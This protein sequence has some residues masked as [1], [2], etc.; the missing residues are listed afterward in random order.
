M[1]G[2]MVVRVPYCK[3]VESQLWESNYVKLQISIEVPISLQTTSLDGSQP[4]ILLDALTIQIIPTHIFI[5]HL[6]FL[7]E[8]SDLLSFPLVSCPLRK[9][10]EESLWPMA[11][12]LFCSY[13]H[14][15]LV[16]KRLTYM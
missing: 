3:N 9:K 15:R 13:S 5:Q 11:M 16:P 4:M 12:A 1:L 6:S 8:I 10:Q 7:P 2:G 14:T